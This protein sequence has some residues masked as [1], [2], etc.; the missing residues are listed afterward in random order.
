MRLPLTAIFTA[1]SAL[2]AATTAPLAKKAAPAKAKAAAPAASAKALPAPEKVTRVEGIT[3]YRLGNGM[4]VLLFP[5]PTKQTVTVNLTYL[6]GS[7]NEGYGETGMAHLLEHM[8]FKGSDR[9]PNLN[10]EL[11]KR[12]A[13]SNASTWFDRTNYFE[14]LQASGENLKWALE[15]EADRMLN[16]HVWKKD[17]DTE[18]TVVRNEFESGENNPAAI[19]EER[20]LSTAFL[21]HNY[22][23]STIGARADIENVPIARLQAF[24]HNYYQP[25]N[26]IL[27]VAGKFDE[28]KTLALIHTIFSPLP[29]PA[30]L[31]QATYTAEPTQDGERAV[32][33]RRAG[34]VQALSVAYHAPAAAH[35]DAAAVSVLVEALSA[36][37]SGRLHKALVEGG[38]ASS[39]GGYLMPTLEPGYAVFSAEVRADA[40]LDAAR[41]EML[42][43]LDAAGSV[44]FTPEEIERVK[45]NLLKEFD[46]TLNDSMRVGL[47]LSESIAAGD[48]R[49]FFLGRD[50]VKAVTPADVGRVAAAYLKPS[51]R[52]V[53]MFIPEKNSDRAVIPPAPDIAALV[54]DYKGEPEMAQGEAFDPSPANIESRTTRRKLEGGLKLALLPKKTRGARV[55]LALTL[56]FG[57]EK[58]LQGRAT[59]GS[60]MADMLMRGTLRHTRQQIKDE[61]DRLKARV[62]VS[63]S[64]GALRLGVETTRG[65]LAAV[66][67]LAGEVL[68]QPAFPAD[69]FEQLRQEQLAASEQQLSEPWALASVALGQHLN[70]W[71]KEDPRY[72]SSPAE[73]IA[74]LKAA[75]LEQAKQFYTDFLGASDGE[76]AAVGD[77]DPAELESLAQRLW[78]G[79]KSPKPFARLGSPYQ[80]R[81]AINRTLEAPDKAN[82]QFSAGLNVKLRDDDAD[83]P[84]LMLGNYLLGE[85]PSSRMWTRIREHEG[86]SYGV[87]TWISANPF[88]DGGSFGG[89][90]IHAPQN[91]AKLEAAFREELARA[92]KDGFTAE[93]IASAKSGVMQERQMQRAQDNALASTLSRYLYYGRTL[94]WDEAHEKKLMALTPEQI[95]AALRAHLDPAAV[96]IVKAGDYAGAA[97]APPA[98]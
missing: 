52:T 74:E 33:L 42:K 70:P 76:L 82:A 5:D 22:G 65:N 71:P 88:D 55:N 14:I 92:L 93:E 39:V 91:G 87:G 18:M 68:R 62:N 10:E 31:L 3:E 48:W 47:A 61:F 11:T 78:G 97:K 2:F 45:G 84:A 35:A 95:T 49:L 66:L 26:G 28:A 9:H 75:K 27:L 4:R 40:P 46:L 1:S 17:L 24:F 30:R 13:W 38:K 63:G 32:T 23:H 73:D 51:N 6:V 8:M 56:H 50:Q 85:S 29:R 69:Q 37:P 60:L 72:V 98:K 81:P 15:M 64:P 19:L 58:S 59:A 89:Y 94:A 90:A 36:T 7:R 16:A 86:L 20:V 77:F 67:E 79:W 54:K 53:G 83:Y 21:W 41:A 12:G 96:S 34:D 43:T 25:D 57:D 44:P 80:A